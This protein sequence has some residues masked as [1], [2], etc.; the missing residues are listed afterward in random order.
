MA[1]TNTTTTTTTLSMKLLIDRKA[2]RLLFAEASKDVV[3]FLCSL[4][5][6][7]VGAA[8]KLLG[9]EGVAGSVGSLYGSVEG[10][11]YTY[12]QPGAAKDALLRP[13]VLC[14]LDSSSLLRLLPPQRPATAAARP[15]L[16]L[17]RCTSIF[18]SSCRTYITE[19]A[20][21]TCGNHM[22][23]A[24]QYLPPAAGGQMPVAGFVRG[25]VTYTV[26]DNLTVMPMSAI[27]S[28]TLLNAFAVTD[29][30]ALQEKTVQLGYNEGLEILRASLQSKTVL[31]DVFLGR[32]GSGDAS[33]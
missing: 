14:S 28:F 23:A 25:V 33:S 21:P 18:N 13:A 30:A 11:D 16:L 3:D 17:Y 29:L 32:K 10:L 8:V 22:T 5:V 1:A 24:A 20:C 19:R 2:Q 27:S 15:S 26:M 7:P 9:K 31:S 6:L 4:L 12:I